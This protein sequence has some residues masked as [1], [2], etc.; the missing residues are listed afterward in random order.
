MPYFGDSQVSN[1]VDYRQETPL[2]S[3]L[4]SGC[5]AQCILFGIFGVRSDFYGNVTVNPVRTSLAN[6]LE[7]KGLKLRGKTIDITVDAGKYVVVCD[8]KRISNK[9]GTPTKLNK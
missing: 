8:G 6:K 5:V 2:Q 4:G 7:L 1:E 9:I 3:D